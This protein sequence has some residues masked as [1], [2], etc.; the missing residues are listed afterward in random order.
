MAFRL[1]VWQRKF[2]RAVACGEFDQMYVH[3][4]RR[5]G[6]TIALRAA[7]LLVAVRRGR[8]LRLA[9]QLSEEWDVNG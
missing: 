1:H 9:E 5:G 2:A 8:A 7:R 6:K 4:P 3:W